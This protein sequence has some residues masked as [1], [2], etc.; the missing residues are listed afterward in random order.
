MSIKKFK[1]YFNAKILSRKLFILIT[2]KYSVLS[3]T[4]YLGLLAGIVKL[5]FVLCL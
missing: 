1:I 2:K 3:Q 5:L 4:L